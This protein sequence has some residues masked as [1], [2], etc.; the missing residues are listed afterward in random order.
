MF[1]AQCYASER[2]HPDREELQVGR[3]ERV[4]AIRRIQEIRGG[5]EVISYVTST[6]RGLEAQMAMDVITPF[7]R[8][9]RALSGPRDGRRIDLFLLSNGGDSI[10][11]WKLVTLI[12]SYCDEFNILVPYRAFSAATLMALGAD[13]VV[14]HPM[15]MLGPTDASINSPFNP[16]NPRNEKELLPVS[17]EDVSSYIALIKEDVGIRHEDELIQAFIALADKVHPLVLGSVKRTT[18]QS[19]MLGQKLLQQRRT[20]VMTPG[21]IEEVVDKLTSKLFFHGH[22]INSVEA[23]DE[24][25]LHFVKSADAETADAIWNLYEVYEKDLLLDTPFDIKREASAKSPLEVPPALANSQAP[26]RLPQATVNLGPYQ[27]AII[28]SASRTESNESEF[29]V[30]LARDAL[31]QYQTGSPQSRREEWVEDTSGS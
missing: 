18:S 26:Q 6:R 4:D 24:L 29:E 3:A 25:G 11:P 31:G 5:T 22:P 27:F 1:G 15:G 2:S 21:A 10:V 9:L 7:Y 17:V 14:M 16:R 19:R 8:N 28:E 30:T 13:S 20:D 12:R 23:R